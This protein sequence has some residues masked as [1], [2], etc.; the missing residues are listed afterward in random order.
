MSE[1]IASHTP[2][3]WELKTNGC[4]DNPQWWGVWGAN[5]QFVCGFTMMTPE[6]VPSTRANANLIASA[7]D[8][9]A[10]VE[11]I[12]REP[13]DEDSNGWQQVNLPPHLADALCAAI[14]KAWR[15][16]SPSDQ[17]TLD[18]I[19]ALLVGEKTSVREALQAAFRLGELTGMIK[20]VKT[21]EEMVRDTF[22]RIA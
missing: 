2:G 22:S 5:G 16:I 21:G 12:Y 9:L 10:V 4:E 20:M 17:A 6:A 13:W 8:L 15:M 7:P 3:P 19:E 11:A 1:P 18:S 14:K